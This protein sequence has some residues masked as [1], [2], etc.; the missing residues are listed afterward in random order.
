MRPWKA[1]RRAILCVDRVRSPS[2]PVRCGRRVD[3]GVGVYRAPADPGAVRRSATRTRLM[4]GTPPSA[5][6]SD[7]GAPRTRLMHGTQRPEV[8]AYPCASPHRCWAIGSSHAIVVGGRR[9]LIG[10]HVEAMRRASLHH[11]AKLF[12]LPQEACVLEPAGRTSPAAGMARR[13]PPRGR[14]PR[15]R[16]FGPDEPRRGDAPHDPVISTE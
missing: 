14:S 16:H 10:G 4:S 5:D 13:A 12:S 2:N 15:S 3:L 9:T 11:L 7:A 6:R 8:F 1:E